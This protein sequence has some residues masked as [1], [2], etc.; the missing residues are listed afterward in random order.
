MCNVQ[1]A[2]DSLWFNKDLAR[3]LGE[4]SRKQASKHFLTLRAFSTNFTV[5][6]P[7][8]CVS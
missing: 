3:A 4:S 2:S 5:T 1:E 7:R 8:N 6:C